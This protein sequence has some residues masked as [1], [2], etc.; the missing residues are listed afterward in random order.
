[1]ERA[2]AREAGEDR[3]Q[4]TSLA[5]GVVLLCIVPHGG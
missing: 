2:L 1:M 5:F 4:G 3:S